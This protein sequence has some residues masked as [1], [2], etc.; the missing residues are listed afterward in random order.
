[1]TLFDGVEL[2]KEGQ[3]CHLLSFLPL[4]LLHL[5]FDVLQR[6]SVLGFVEEPDFGRGFL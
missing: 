3:T 6:G 4:W 2:V 1:M 5:D